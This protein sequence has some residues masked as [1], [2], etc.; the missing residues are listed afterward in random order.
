MRSPEMCPLLCWVARRDKTGLWFVGN[1]GMEKR[2]ETTIMG[3][4]GIA[5]R[6]HSFIPSYWDG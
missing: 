6:I 1:E 3:D 5:I 2:M 4:I